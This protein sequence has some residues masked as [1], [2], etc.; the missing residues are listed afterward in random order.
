MK[1]KRITLAVWAIGLA[2]LAGQARAQVGACCRG[3]A[4][5]ISTDSAGCTTVGGQ[6]IGAGTSC[7][8]TVCTGACCLLTGSCS[9]SVS[10]NSCSSGGFFQGAGSTCALNCPTTLGTGFTYQGQL[11]QNGV[12]V[13]DTADVRVT[14]RDRAV[15]GFLLG[16]GEHNVDVVNG[17]FLVE[18]DFGFTVFDGDSRWLEVAVRVPHDPTNTAPFTTLQP[19]QSITPVPYAITALDAPVGHALDAPD[20][21]PTNAVFVNNAGN[22]GIGNANPQALLQVG[23]AYTPSAAGSVARFNGLLAANGDL[24][25]DQGNIL[26]RAPPGTPVA[27]L[28]ADSSTNPGGATWFLLSHA[29]GSPFG[30]PAGSFSIY[31]GED[32]L[33]ITSSGNVGIGTVPATGEN[34]HVAGDARFD[35]PNGIGV[36]NPNNLGA[37]VRLS[38]LN[39]VPRIRLGGTSPGGANGFDFQKIGDVS[40][41]R[42]LDNGNIGMGTATPA[43]DLHVMD[44]GTARIRVESAAGQAGISF[45]SDSTVE[46]VIYSADGFDDLRLFVNGA[47]R[48][49]I[50]SAGNVGIGTNAPTGKLH[51]SGAANDTSVVLPDDSISSAETLEEPGLASDLRVT[52]A[53]TGDETPVTLASRTITVPTDGFVIAHVCSNFSTLGLNLPDTAD[54]TIFLDKTTSPAATSGEYFRTVETARIEALSFHAVFS[55][56]AGANAFTLTGRSQGLGCN[57]FNPR[58]TLVF[59]PTTYGTTDVE[60]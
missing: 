23:A 6:F 30:S 24:L 47:D 31:N 16:I 32:R 38:W 59:F 27:V 29:T 40:L 52:I 2:G 7:A 21:S 53:L 19:R 54:V 3:D 46:N 50:S 11:K 44:T 8:T 14:V 48:L 36:R 39:D 60:D 5:C 20:G 13:N 37:I 43:N 49:A 22:V 12:P 41:L 10:P 15:G 45:L 4:T 33:A 17:Q 55:V 9:D 28:Q 25:S 42:I 34:L 18:L 1:C 57:A 26:S 56:S 51:V 35:G 58:L